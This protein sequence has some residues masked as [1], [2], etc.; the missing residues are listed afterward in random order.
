MPN[1]CYNYALLSCPSKET[2]DKLVAENKLVFPRGGEGK[3]R[4]KLFLSEKKFSIF[5]YSFLGHI[6]CQ[7]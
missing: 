3:P 1:W 4:Y 7:I 2:Y 6:E 5:Y